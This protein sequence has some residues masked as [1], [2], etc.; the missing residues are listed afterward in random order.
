MSSNKWPYIV[1]FLWAV[2]LIVGGQICSGNAEI[3]SLTMH[4]RPPSSNA[5]LGTDQLGRDVL[6]RI[7]VGGRISLFVGLGSAM[8]AIFIGTLA[9]LIAGYYGGI[10]DN[11][12]MRFL[13][14]VKAIP[15]LI[16]LIFWQSLSQPSLLNVIVI[17]GGVSWLQPAR[18]IR[19]EVLS[20]KEREHIAAAKAI[21]CPAYL[22]LLRHILPYCGS[23]LNVLFI[24]EF[25]RAVLMETTLSFLGLGLPSH[26]PSLGNMLS[27]GLN[28]INWGYWWQVL[29]PGITLVI[30]IILIHACGVEF[31]KENR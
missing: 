9:G 24:L 22:I 28:A 27:N 14:A 25:S 8:L 7:L 11:I 6:A 21:A 31:G 2:L 1:V 13:D 12:L 26:I 17:I 10:V 19:S 20:L 29:F 23:R 15:T 4:N 30:S 16:L 18:I 5:L 3:V